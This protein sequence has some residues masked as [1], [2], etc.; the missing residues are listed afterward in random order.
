[1]RGN[2]IGSDTTLQAMFKTEGR[3]LTF[4]QVGANLIGAYVVSSYFVFFDQV[5]SLESVRSTFYVVAVMFPILVIIANFYF[6]YWQRDLSR[7]IALDI[8]QQKNHPDLLKSARRKVLDLP[9]MSAVIS[10]FNWL[11]AAVIMSA[12]SLISSSGGKETMT[13]RLIDALSSPPS[14]RERPSSTSRTRRPRTRSPSSSASGRRS[15]AA[16]PIR[17]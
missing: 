16:G 5:F 7:F 15:F 14:S 4:W 17:R 8:S 12:H 11:I 13:V 6:H 2:S 9:F 3:R 1:M 10:F